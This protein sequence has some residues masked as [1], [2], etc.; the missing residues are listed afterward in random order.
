MEE[1]SQSEA[2]GI[3]NNLYAHLLYTTYLGNYIQTLRE[4]S[5]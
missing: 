1:A 5:V 3:L 2:S 4:E